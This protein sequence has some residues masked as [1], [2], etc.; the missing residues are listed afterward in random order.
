M[1]AWAAVT[2]AKAEPLL[3]DLERLSHQSPDQIAADV[4]SRSAAAEM[5]GRN[6]PPLGPDVGTSGARQIATDAATEME[7]V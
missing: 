2:G 6:T 3:A 4:L 1:R 5:T 7:L